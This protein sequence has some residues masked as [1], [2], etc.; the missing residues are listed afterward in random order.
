MILP[1]AHFKVTQIVKSFIF[2]FKKELQMTMNLNFI[3]SYMIVRVSYTKCGIK[4]SNFRV[5]VIHLQK[6]D[7][8]YEFQGHTNQ[9]NK[10]SHRT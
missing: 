7:Q 1:W 8:M 9:C 3:I 6:Y 2:V 4:M 5:M 10:W